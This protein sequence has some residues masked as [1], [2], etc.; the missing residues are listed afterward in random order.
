MTATSASCWRL[1]VQMQASKCGGGGPARG[2]P[3]RYC[4]SPALRLPVPGPWLAV[5]LC[6]PALAAGARRTLGGGALTCGEPA[7]WS[8]ERCSKLRACHTRRWGCRRVPPV[9]GQRHHC[10]GWHR[11]AFSKGSPP[12]RTAA[13]TG[14][15]S[16]GLM[17]CPEGCLHPAQGES[18]SWAGAGEGTLKTRCKWMK[19]GDQFN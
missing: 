15:P 8:K 16:V 6:M 7:C 9:A 4:K 12:A 2:A 19:D 5:C 1:A 14:S 18:A 3:C 10:R 17:C 13:S 11:S